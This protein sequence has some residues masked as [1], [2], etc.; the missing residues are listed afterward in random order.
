MIYGSTLSDGAAGDEDTMIAIICEKIVERNQY[1]WYIYADTRRT[2]VSVAA[3]RG[4]G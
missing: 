2:A 4:K 1:D 3:K